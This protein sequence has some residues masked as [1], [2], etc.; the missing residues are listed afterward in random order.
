MVP[1]DAWPLPDS[2][3]AHAP[4]DKDAGNGPAE[5]G[6]GRDADA[7]AADAAASTRDGR[8]DDDGGCS[9]IAVGA[10]GR[11]LTWH[12]LYGDRCNGLVFIG[13]GLAEQ[14]GAAGDSLSAC[15]CL[16]EGALNL[17]CSGQWSEESCLH[18]GDPL[19]AA[20]QVGVTALGSGGRSGEA[21]VAQAVAEAASSARKR[22][23]RLLAWAQLAEDEAAQ[24]EAAWEAWDCDAEW[25]ALLQE[26]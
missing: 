7:A 3:S 14:V 6:N 18:A 24:G 13:L 5:A 11:G 19:R 17:A 2:C 16:A 12:P 22:L 26:Y 21:R 10:G 9:S 4:H 15:S 20:A 1:R 25:L 8:A 23:Q